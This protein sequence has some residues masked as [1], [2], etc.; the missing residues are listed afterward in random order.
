MET[1]TKR[2][3]LVLGLEVFIYTTAYSTTLFVSKADSTGYLHLLDLPK[4]S[5]SPIREISFAFIAFL[6]EQRR[7][8]DAQFIINLFARSQSQYLFPGSMDY[9]GKHVLDDRGLV[10]WWCRV[11]HPFL[12][13]YEDAVTRGYLVVP[14][15]EAHETKALLPRASSAPWILGHPLERTS[16]Y[17]REFD[18]VPPRCLIPHFPDDPKSRFRDELDEEAASSGM[19]KRTGNWKNVKTLDMF[20][21][22]MAYRQECSSGRMTGFLWVVFDDKDKDKTTDAGRG[23]SQPGVSMMKPPANAAHNTTTP[24]KLVPSQPDVVKHKLGRKKSTYQAIT[25][26]K[27]KLKGIIKP[28]MPKVKTRQKN[29]LLEIPTSTAHYYWPCGGRGERIVDETDYKRSV[30]L[31]LHLDFGNFEKAASSTQRWV[32][33]VGMGQLWG[34]QVTGT[35]EPTASR[36]TGDNAAPAVNTLTGLVKRKWTDS[37]AETVNG[38]PAGLVQKKPKEEKQ[39]GQETPPAVNVLTAGLGRKKAKT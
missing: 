4:G 17:Y 22:M 32:K 28:R 24:K 36:K 3:V 29:Y 12:R 27:R 5:A 2:H 23:A 26:K 39:E 9:H 35:A 33:E 37:G 38:L 19:M 31:L 13:E 14:G 15:L 7:R 18:W 25:G 6:V 16:H 1:E 20:W 21:E 11:L 8:K 10:R 34:W 30:E